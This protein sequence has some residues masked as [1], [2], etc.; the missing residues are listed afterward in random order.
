MVQGQLFSHGYIVEHHECKTNNSRLSCHN[1]A[2]TIEGKLGF[3]R[4]LDI[5]K[6]E[7]DPI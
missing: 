1:T 5:S 7:I 3:L 2:M 4:I 6:I